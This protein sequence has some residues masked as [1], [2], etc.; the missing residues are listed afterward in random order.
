MMEKRMR[1]GGAH[2]LCCSAVNL[3][4][5]P[6]LAYCDINGTLLFLDIARDRYFCLRGPDNRKALAY[7]DQQRLGRSRQ[8]KL[9]PTNCEISQPL[10]SS[11]AISTGHFH[12]G[13]IARAL[14]VQRRVE[15]QLASRPFHSIIMDL[16]T[17][18]DS[19]AKEE[20]RSKR[21]P[22]TTI[23]AFEYSRLLRTAANRCLPRSIALALCLA[24]EGMRANV[25]LG[26]KRGPF[27]AHCWV[28]HRTEVLNDSVEE[29]LRYRPILVI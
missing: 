8:P 29:V 3:F 25:V 11:S 10:V 24:S 21:T 17:L 20:S 12:I 19:R 1:A 15:R 6:D 5:N 23:R 4:D 9:G 13:D 22:E 28:Q 26:V 7:L 16:A 18:L 27:G 2:P 14:W